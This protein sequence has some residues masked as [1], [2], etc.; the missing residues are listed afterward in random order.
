M[1]ELKLLDGDAA[2]YRADDGRVERAARPDAEAVRAHAAVSVG[3]SERKRSGST[4]KKLRQD[5]NRL[6]RARRGRYRERAHAG[7]RARRIRDFPRSGNAQ[8][9]GR[10]TA[11]RCCR[12]R[13]CGVRAP[14]DRGSCRAHGGASVALLRV[15]GKPIAA[16]VLLYSGTMAYTW[17]TAFDA[18]FAKFSP[19]ALLIDKVTDALFAAGIAQI[20]SCSPDG[21]F[22]AQLWTGRRTTVDMLVDVGGKQVG[23]LRARRIRRARLRVR[24]RAARPAAR[25]VWLPAAEAKKS[26]G[27]AE[28]SRRGAARGRAAVLPHWGVSLA[29][30][31]SLGAGVSAIRQFRG[32]AR[33]L[34]LAAL[35]CCARGGGAR[36]RGMPL[37]HH[38]NRDGACRDR[39]R[40]RARGRPHGAARRDRTCASQS[41]LPAGTA[42]TLKRLGSCRDRPLRPP[43]CPCFHR[44]KRRAN[45]GSRPIWSRRGLARVS[46]RVGDTAC[47]RAL[48]AEEQAARAAKLGLWG[49]PVYVMGKAEDPAGVLKS[50]GR[51]ALVEGKVALGARKRRHDLREFRAALVGGLHRHDRQAQ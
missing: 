13:G 25:G 8:L 50:R 45:A 22:M 7:R 40:H 32:V 18:E 43:Q 34:S 29:S 12:R 10:R 47:A 46:S 21:S 23:R 20:E 41:A 11:R 14:L 15:D 9:E 35:A 2:T 38:R 30:G 31:H 39:S 44:R 36:R 3:E 17:K 42:L 24:A 48:L 37:R 6:S 49:E 28:L 51:F 33:A 4:G 26:R 16:Q 19:G 1:I 5:W 27:H